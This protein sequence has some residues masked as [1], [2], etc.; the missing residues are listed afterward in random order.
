MAT[1]R[2][3]EGSTKATPKTHEVYYKVL[4]KKGSLDR[5][6]EWTIQVIQRPDGSFTET[7]WSGYHGGRLK[8]S[9][10][11]SP[12]DAIGKAHTKTDK[13]RREGY[14]DTIEDARNAEVTLSGM[15]AMWMELPEI[16]TLGFRKALDEKFNGLRGTYH[17]DQDVIISKGGKVYDVEHLK[18]ELRDFSNESGLGIIDFELYAPGYK[19]NEIASMVKNTANPERYKLRA[20]IFDALADRHD[21]LV[22]YKRKHRLEQSKFLMTRGLVLVRSLIF[23]SALDIE[24]FYT[25]V[26]SRGGEGIIVRDADKSYDW[27]N[28]SR[29]SSVMIK[30]K[31]LITREFLAVGCS[32]ETRLHNGEYKKLII[33]TCVTEDGKTFSVTPE[34]EVDDR[35]IP[36]PEFNEDSWYTI[37]FREY[38]AN[39]IPFHGVGKGFRITEDLDTTSCD[40]D[41]E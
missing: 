7:T 20:Y 26:T 2:N 25:E 15:Q 17:R 40:T 9:S 37:E 41:T 23:P 6:K 35:C 38:T 13:K 30:A 8:V 32:F 27:D 16:L 24:T 22:C 12:G 1:V 21:K 4:Y 11:P 29:R 36:A 5:I 28:R 3:V 10:K 18:E 33:Y 34:G 14:V 19:V 31:P 39:G